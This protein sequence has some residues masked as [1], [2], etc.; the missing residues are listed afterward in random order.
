[1]SEMTPIVFTFFP[2]RAAIRLLLPAGIA[3]TTTFRAGVYSI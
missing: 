3:L 2:E 1:V